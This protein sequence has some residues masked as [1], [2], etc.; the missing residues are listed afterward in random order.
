MKRSIFSALLLLTALVCVTFSVSAQEYRGTILGR[1]LDPGGAAVAGAGVEI[2]NVETNARIATT[3]NSEGNY[4]A[5]FLL[6]GLYKVRVTQSGFKPVERQNVRVLTNA[7]VTIDLALEIGDASETVTIT[8]NAPLLTTSNSDLGQVIERTYIDTV[9]M[10]L[11]RN[12]NTFTRLAP[13]V[14]GG[15]SSVTGNN[16]GGF[17][18]AG[19]GSTVG[20]VE[21]TVDGIPN[22][23]PQNNGGVVFVP[24]VDAVQEVKIHTTMFDAANGRSNGG[25]IN[26]TTR[27][28]GNDLHGVVYL[29]KQWA[30]TNANSWNNNR[31]KLPKPPVD[32][33]Q[34]GHFISGPVWL[35][36]LYN[37]KDRTFF[38]TSFETDTDARALTRQTR[39][40]TTLERQGDFS[41]TLN[42]QGNA[43]IRIYDPLTTVVTG[44]RA[45]RQEF[46]G[47][48]IPTNRLNPAG[49]AYLNLMP[50]PNIAG[51]PQ[52]N[53]FNWSDTA[54][55]TVRQRNI[56]NRIDH[57][58]SDKQR[59]FVR[60]G[61]L[62]RDQ[63][64][65]KELIR[66]IWGFNTNNAVDSAD[67]GLLNRKFYNVGVDDTITFSPTLVGSFRYG[68]VRKENASSRGG[69]GYDT[70][71]LKIPAQIASNQAIKGWPTFNLGESTAA[72][73]SANAFDSN[74]VSVALATFTKLI[75][76]HSLK[77]GVDYRLTRWHRDSPGD[78]APGSFAFNSIF[79][80]QDP[81]TNASSNTTGTALASLLLGLPASG[82][83]GFNSAQSLQ[84]HYLA[85][86]L[87]ED[88]KVNRKLT[89]NL[90]LRYDLE[91]P[92][93]E[94]FNRMSYG[95]DPNAVL[96]VQ[97]P[98]LG[99]QLRGAILLAG[100][101]GNPRAGGNLDKNN[102]G[103]RFGFAYSVNQKTVV[104][105]GY[106][107]FYSGQTFN[108]A[109]LANVGVF[110]ANT[111]YIGTTDNGAT[112]FTTIDNPF[113]NGLVT[114]RG[115]DVGLQA[116]LGDSVD[117]YDV[118]RVSP[119]NQ[120]W[121]LSVQ[122]EL[123]WQML[124]EAAYVGV[125]SFKQFETFNLNE[126]PDQFLAQGAAENNRV[127]NPFL[128]VFPANSTLGQ[129]A[130]ITQNRLWVRYPQFVNLT[131]HGAN[132]GRAS[133]HGLQTKIDKRLTNGLNFLL[134]YT[135]SK[136]LDNET[137]SLVNTRK[138]RTVSALDAPHI[139]RLATVYQV[140]LKFSGSFGHKLLDYALGGWS[141]SGI[142]ELTSGAPLGAVIDA[143]GRMNRL[144]SPRLD[145]DVRDR[146][147]DQRDA[148][149]NILNPYF[150]LTAFQGL[151]NQF[152]VASEG[153]RYD[154][155]RAP[156]ARSLNLSVF[157]NFQIVERLKLQ[158]RV[159]AANVTNTPAFGG[160]GLDAR[161]RSTF[162][163]V[164]A[165]GNPRGIQGALRLLF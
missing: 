105:G 84:Q 139:F 16:A 40:P 91:T 26:L 28:G 51:A 158:L 95:F 37:G 111:S 21:F 98:L 38:S 30:A 112:P 163:V 74:D 44:G 58:I 97:A 43:L 101:S 137:T 25:A 55:Y 165:G 11:S 96:P 150:D 161:N 81:F 124:A 75:G 10:S 4:Q 103:P 93:T 83:L 52:I 146:L 69:T 14:T 147:G 89:L 64:V 49:V 160:I 127:P 33:Y 7:Q 114:P 136:L 126:K 54:T 73:G 63:A 104:R 3:T 122:R 87:Q 59:I 12:V 99:A 76:K 22:T 100:A 2:T 159:D 118:N 82:G 66:G 6:P 47:A 155:L 23:A 107:L 138:Y 116:Q 50:Q 110:N 39:V 157:K 57:I 120:Q 144:R 41:Q 132:T 48:R 94:R 135:F 145:G 36:K 80:R 70:N 71:E 153:P 113:P 27:S 68:F 108:D 60:F 79:T 117:F 53:K 17:S 148:A 67:L 102:F 109:F 164:T 151:P 62:T 90:G 143:N 42:S 1:V 142:L 149:G 128:N 34:Y 123:P 141:V 20:R 140:P 121:Q 35:P 115:A 5:P 24:S 31:L 65:D 46:A 32:F 130:T 129:G 162:G 133:Y 45:T 19:G 18:I 15:Q 56:N 86:Y 125:T 152:T 29:Y 13:G 119:Y 156:S 88:W 85:L 78:N 77:F 72:I 9:A 106:G 134:S 131:V 61:L 8:D 92:W 154:D